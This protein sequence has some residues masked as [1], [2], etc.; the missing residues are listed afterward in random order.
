MDMVMTHLH[1][2][3]SDVILL[4]NIG[5]QFPYSLLD[6]AVQNT[7]P[8]FGRPNQMVQSLVDRMRGASENHADTCS[9]SS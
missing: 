3:K 8:I 9:R 4:R 6:L 2:L 1:F 7:A 5:K